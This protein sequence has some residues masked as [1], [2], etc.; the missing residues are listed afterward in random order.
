MH[1]LAARRCD[2][3]HAIAPRPTSTA[4]ATRPVPTPRLAR[5]ARA[6]AGIRP[7]VAGTTSAIRRCCARSR[8]RRRSCGCGDDVAVLAAAGGRHRRVARGHAVRARGRRAARRASSRTRGLLVVSRPGARRGRRGASRAASAA[9]GAT[10]ARARLRARHHLSARTSR[11]GRKYLPA[12]GRW[13]ASSGP[14]APPLPEHF[15]L[16]NRIISGISLAVVVVEASSK[17]GSLITARCALEQGRDVMAVP[18]SVPRRPQPRIARAPQGRRKG[19]RDCGRYLGGA[20]VARPE[21]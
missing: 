15:P 8:I 4:A 14:G 13:S 5:H 17:S 6:S 3:A 9:G 7:A 18:G 10:V 21:R 1:D 2:R 16:R 12:T 19:R 11:S 20:G